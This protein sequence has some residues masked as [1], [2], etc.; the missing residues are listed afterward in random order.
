MVEIT[1]PCLAAIALDQLAVLFNFHH[2]LKGH[3]DRLGLVL[4][5]QDSLRLS[6]QTMIYAERC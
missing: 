2:G 4:C 5:A 3:L 1:G 6:H